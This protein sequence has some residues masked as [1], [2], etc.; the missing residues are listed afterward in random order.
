MGAKVETLKKEV[1]D[2]LKN[3]YSKLTPNQGK[4]GSLILSLVIAL[5]FIC[6]ATGRSVIVGLGYLV[7][8]FLIFAFAYKLYSLV[9]E[10]SKVEPEKQDEIPKAV[11]EEDC[12]QITIDELVA[13][14]NAA[15]A[16][17]TTAKKE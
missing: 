17:E 12:H 4:Y 13:E 8:A 5:V 2:I 10:H 7:F 1:G 6:T 9:V 16:K 15:E 11:Q 14:A 3:I